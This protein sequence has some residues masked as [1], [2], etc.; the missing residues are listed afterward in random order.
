MLRLFDQVGLNKEVTNSIHCH[1][2]YPMLKLISQF[3]H[4]CYGALIVKHINWHAFGKRNS[5]KS[6]KRF[7]LAFLVWIVELL[8]YGNTLQTFRH[9]FLYSPHLHRW[10]LLLYKFLPWSLACC[11]APHLL[12]CPIFSHDFS[13]W[14]RMILLSRFYYKLI[15]SSK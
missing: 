1:Q 12:F 9:S 7:R 4:T 15:S 11:G 5:W 6:H 10:C 2:I 3:K 13:F 14:F 8:E